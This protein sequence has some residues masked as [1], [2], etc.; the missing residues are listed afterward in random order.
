VA[1]CA[2]IA[3]CSLHVRDLAALTNLFKS[4]RYYGPWC[5]CACL[6]P[7]ASVSLPVCLVVRVRAFLRVSLKVCVRLSGTWSWS[8]TS[9][10]H[11]PGAPVPVA[12]RLP[13]PPPLP[14]SSARAAR[15][16]LVREYSCFR[17][18]SHLSTK[19]A[20]GTGKKSAMATRVSAMDLS[21]AGLHRLPTTPLSAHTSISTPGVNMPV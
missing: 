18:T 7:C 9:K 8:T 2:N 17:Y 12:P 19:N 6:L 13:P 14:P 1:S 10:S 4:V 3:L 5:H 15:T 21:T 20:Y 11:C 16:A